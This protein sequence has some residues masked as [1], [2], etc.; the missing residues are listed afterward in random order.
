GYPVAVGETTEI[1][2][3]RPD[4]GVRH[5][6]L[7]VTRSEWRDRPVCLVA[8]RDITERREAEER[9][10]SLIREHVARVEAEAGERR[11]TFL[12]EAS[13]VLGSSLDLRTTLQQLAELSVPMLGDCCIIDT[14]EP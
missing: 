8:I 12:S 7:R 5:A 10:R 1:E 2:V 11:A 6:E 14:V 4:G 9:E 3:V 13:R